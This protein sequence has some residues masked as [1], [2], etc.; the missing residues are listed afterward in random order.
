MRTINIGMSGS[1]IFSG[2]DAINDDN[3]NTSLN[4][5]SILLGV[6]DFIK[7]LVDSGD[8]GSSRSVIINLGVS[9]Y[10]Y[11]EGGGGKRRR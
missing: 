10:N 7:F 11:D 8:S 1:L 2:C 5:G 4:T 6:E 9:S 3:R